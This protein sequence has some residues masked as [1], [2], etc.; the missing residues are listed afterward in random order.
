MSTL[1]C[2]I[3]SIYSSVS[4]ETA[5]GEDTSSENFTAA[6]RTL[7]FGAVVHVQNEENGHTVVVRITDR[8]PF[9]AGRIID[10]SQIAARE[11]HFTGL[12]KVC[13]RIV[14][15]PPNAGGGK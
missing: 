1:E 5:S 14:W 2:G 3:A 11:L 6:H 10:V 12:A 4:E 9:V 8:G 15:T 13:L 7:P